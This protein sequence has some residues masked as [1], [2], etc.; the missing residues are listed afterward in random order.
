MADWSSQSFDGFT[1][2]RHSI[3]YP[4]I[5]PER[6]TLPSPYVAVVIGASK[7]IGA[8][9]AKAFATA[10]AS[11]LVITAHDTQTLTDTKEACNSI[12]PNCFVAVM[13]C[14]ITSR[15][16]VVMLHSFIYCVF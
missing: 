16:S 4:V 12:N 9:I 6:T 14:D 8:G 13:E 1:S 3:P 2:T 10:G 15:R 5:D 7:G 11:V